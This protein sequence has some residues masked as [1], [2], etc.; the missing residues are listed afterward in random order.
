MADIAVLHARSLLAARENLAAMQDPK[1]TA[2]PL[3]IASTAPFAALAAFF[4]FARIYSRMVPA[5]H[6]FWD[7]YLITLGFVRYIRLNRYALTSP[8][9][10]FRNM[11]SYVSH[12]CRY[13][14]TSYSLRSSAED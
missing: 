6:L 10:C 4:Y 3:F 12:T 7:D 2:E 9:V 14:S 8:G 13:W 1:A 5:I 11:G